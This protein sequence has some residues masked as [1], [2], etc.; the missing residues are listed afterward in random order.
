MDGEEVKEALD[1]LREEVRRGARAALAAKLAAE[2]AARVPADDAWVS[3]LLP[4]LDALERCEVQ[5]GELSADLAHPRGRWPWRRPAEPRAAVLAEGVRIVR[6]SLEGALAGRGY[7]LER[8]RGEPFD[9]T[10]HRAVDT[11]PGGQAGRVVS[12]VRA[13]VLRGDRVV[14]E[15][16]VVV[17]TSRELEAP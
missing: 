12:V 9:A 17:G 16:E 15:A 8:P 11:R 3:G 7:R 2:E 4:V 1:A 10:R 5:A 14:R 6:E 13:G